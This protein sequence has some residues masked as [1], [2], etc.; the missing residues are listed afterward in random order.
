MDTVKDMVSIL[1]VPE[2]G[3]RKL[4]PAAQMAEL[5]VMLHLLGPETVVC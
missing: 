2:G 3:M 5:R 4:R 1:S